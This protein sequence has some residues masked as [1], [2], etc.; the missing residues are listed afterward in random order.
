VASRP[1]AAGAAV[2]LIV[3]ATADSAVTAPAQR[4]LA[5]KIASVNA[6]RRADGLA[7]LHPLTARDRSYARRIATETLPLTHKPYTAHG[8]QNELY[9]VV[10][11]STTANTFGGRITDSKTGVQSIYVTSAGYTKLKQVLGRATNAG[12]PVRLVKVAR[13]YQDLKNVTAAI[14]KEHV[15]IKAAG[16]K[17]NNWGPSVS[18]NTVNVEVSSNRQVAQRY[19]DKRFGAGV[20]RVGGSL[21][22]AEPSTTAPTSTDDSQTQN[23]YYDMSP[24]QVGDRIYL[25]STGAGCTGGFFVM[26]DNDHDAYG[27]TAGHCGSGTVTTNDD[28]HYT[29]G[30]VSKNYFDTTGGDY[31]FST[32]ACAEVCNGG[33]VWTEF[34]G[35]PPAFKG[36]TQRCG[37][38]CGL[39]DTV[40]IDGATQGEHDNNTITLANRCFMIYGK[41]VCHLNQATNPNGSSSCKKGD[42]GGPVYQNQGNNI[43]WATGVIVGGSKATTTEPSGVRC[44]YHPL[45][46]VVNAG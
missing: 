35:F 29:M 41:Q 14:A 31:D 26:G 28:E 18:S 9:R 19:F 13:S 30:T 40:A 7:P 2:I 23:R 32:F 44:L 45:S 37:D 10:E 46:V 43:V 27:L 15:Q 39:G 8:V 36:V 4:A 20:V 3:A 12:G 17:L 42:S 25:S 34:E 5:A 22:Y 33:S 16:I 38:S 11:S 24:F 6:A 21:F 1:A